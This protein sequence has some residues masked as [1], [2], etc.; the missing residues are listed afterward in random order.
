MPLTIREFHDDLAESFH[1]INAEWIE[2]MFSLEVND[3]QL[4]ENPREMIVDRGGEILFVEDSELGILGTCALLCI[5]PGVFELT[6]MGVLARSRG[7]KAGE[8]LLRAVL[9]RAASL[10]ARSLYL[11]TNK[12]CEAA[13]HLY[14]KVGFVH[15][16]QILATY[17]PRYERCDVAMSFPLEDTAS[18]ASNR[19]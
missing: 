15:D 1:R 11:L 4:L 12:K 9:E 10:G 8:F 18:P 19:A 7:K 3:R 5:E 2:A 16:A 13:I 17:G 14:E 6:K